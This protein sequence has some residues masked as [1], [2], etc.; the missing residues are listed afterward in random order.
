MITAG[1]P[2]RANWTTSQ[3]VKGIHPRARTFKRKNQCHHGRNAQRT[4]SGKIATTNSRKLL[5]TVA[6]RTTYEFQ[7]ARL[8]P[9]VR[10]ISSLRR[11]FRHKFHD[12]RMQLVTIVPGKLPPCGQTA[13][14][15][16]E[17]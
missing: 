13:R 4:G 16:S 6:E 9:S 10:T 7:Y 12:S 15:F 11:P 17:S 14:H 8:V 2:Y 1:F 3:I 5:T